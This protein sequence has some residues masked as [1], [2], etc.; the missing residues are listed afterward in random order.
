LRF[1][2]ALALLRQGKR[3]ELRRIDSAPG[4]LSEPLAMG[5]CGDRQ[6]A[7]ALRKKLEANAADVATITALGIL[8]DVTVIRALLNYLAHEELGAT[9]A[10]ALYWITG[11][12]L[13]E[14]VFVAEEVDEAALFDAELRAWRE[15]RELPRRADGKPFG[16]VVNQLS[17]DPARWNDWLAAH[18]A[19][20]NPEYRYRRGQLYSARSLLGCLLESAVPQRLR[21]LAYE[22]LC[23]RYKCAI[24]FEADY[25]VGE[26]RAALTAIADWVAQSEGHFDSGRW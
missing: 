11:A 16:D 23:I 21:Q 4:A 5:L 9:S 10:L 12:R 2:A 25:R 26:Q 22:E 20:F 7:A 18:A 13:F 15:R 19:Q 1:N 24:P 6:T 8:G 3:N 14:N 17:R